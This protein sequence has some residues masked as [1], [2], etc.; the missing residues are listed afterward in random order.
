MR[1]NLPPPA[2]RNPRMKESLIPHCRFL[3]APLLALWLAV[4]TVGSFFSPAAAL[5]APAS[6]EGEYQ[7]DDCQGYLKIE[8]QRAGA[9]KVWLGVGGG[10][11]GGEVLVDRPVGYSG[12]PLTIEHTLNRKRCTA[13]IDFSEDGASVSDSCISSE[14]EKTSTCALLGPYSR[15]GK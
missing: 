15:Q 8:K 5:S 4:I 2:L 3:R 7:C 9:Y 1:T 13:R 11:C 14:D 10:S 12:G 6:I